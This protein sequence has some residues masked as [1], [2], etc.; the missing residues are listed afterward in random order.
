MPRRAKKSRREKPTRPETV[1]NE[2][3]FRSRRMLRRMLR[4]NTRVLKRCGRI[5]AYSV[6]YGILI[7]VLL[8]VLYA[9][10]TLTYISYQSFSQSFE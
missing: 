10:F 1:G 2:Q 5:I 7:F 3:K 8:S 6:T 9:I 4:C